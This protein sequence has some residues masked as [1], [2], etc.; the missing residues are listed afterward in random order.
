MH[1][2]P[3]RDNFVTI[4]LENVK[5]K[6]KHN[7]DILDGRKFSNFNTTYD[8]NSVMH[9]DRSA[10]SMNG[11]DTIVPK[12]M[13]YI[14]DIGEAVY[15]SSGDVERLRSMYKCNENGDDFIVNS[16]ADDDDDDDDGNF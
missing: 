11:Q 10:F 14:D 8:Y 13:S 4:D 5:D 7:F 12:N 16:N 2:S 9:Y 15:L 6:K 1:N 3:D